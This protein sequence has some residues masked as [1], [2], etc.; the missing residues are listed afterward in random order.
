MRVRLITAADEDETGR[1]STRVVDLTDPDAATQPGGASRSLLTGLWG[2]DRIPPLPQLR[3]D[4]EAYRNALRDAPLAPYDGM[5]A[6]VA[7]VPPGMGLNDATEVSG[8]AMHRTDS[9]DIIV[10]LEGELVFEQ[11]G[12][13]L[14]ITAGDTVILHGTYHRPVNRSGKPFT[15]VDLQFS[16]P[17]K[18]TPWHEPAVEEVPGGWL[19]TGNE[20]HAFFAETPEKA[21]ALAAVR[22]T[23]RAQLRDEITW[24]G[25]T[26]SDVSEVGAGDANP[27]GPGRI[28]L[29]TTADADEDGTVSTRIVDLTDPSVST[30]PGGPGRARLTG[31]W[32]WDELPTLPLSR[33][34]VERY[35]TTLAKGAYAPYGG[36]RA[37]L[38]TVPPR[39]GMNDTTELSGG[40]MHRTD[41]IDIVIG[42]EGELVFE[43]PGA[44]ITITPGDI[45]I[46][47][48]TYHRP[49]NRS[50]QPFV[51]LDFQYTTPR[52]DTP[53]YDPQIREVEGGWISTGNEGFTF[54]EETRE[55]AE[56]LTALREKWRE[57][58]KSEIT[59]GGPRD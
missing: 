47:H 51:F 26:T 43:Q 18:D 41:T 27:G 38:T 29:I 32:G 59:W 35:R 54:F 30:Q 31:L 52:K 36:M 9:I 17:R 56:A 11:P 23:W 44:D 53:W 33:A 6:F 50:D 28:R 20:G 42:L 3:E 46:L 19:A 40:S 24:G 57:Q 2:W 5:R 1:V 7:V 39:M 48:G 37:Y 25:P 12:G 45:V 55:K 10:A 16:T 13:D 14:T 21:E 22:E 58:A 49:V 4:V 34:D 15:F 8:G